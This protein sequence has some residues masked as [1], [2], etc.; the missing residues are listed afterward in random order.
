MSRRGNCYDNAFA[1]SFFQLRKRE[2]IRRKVYLEREEATRDVS[3]Y[4][5]MF[6]NPKRLHGH[7]NDVS[8]V[9]CEKRYFNRLQSA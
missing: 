9:E 1:E 5:E 8:P 3:N 4:I 2:R 7:A 6:Y